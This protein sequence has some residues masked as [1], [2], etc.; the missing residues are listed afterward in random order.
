MTGL[1]KLTNGTQLKKVTA[2]YLLFPFVWIS[3]PSTRLNRT[4]LES[5]EKSVE[6]IHY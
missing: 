1:M 2:T 6:S 5:Q 4:K 3:S